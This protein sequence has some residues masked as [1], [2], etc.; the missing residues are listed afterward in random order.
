MLV[1]LQISVLLAL[2]DQTDDA[3]G[4]TTEFRVE[5]HLEQVQIIGPFLN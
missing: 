3:L 5:G 2:E 4:T 1:L